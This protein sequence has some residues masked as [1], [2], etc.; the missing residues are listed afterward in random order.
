MFLLLS[1]CTF[2]RFIKAIKAF[3]SFGLNVIAQLEM[4]LIWNF[5]EAEL[6]ATVQ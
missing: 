4:E 1:I 5:W 6:T 2:Y 3:F